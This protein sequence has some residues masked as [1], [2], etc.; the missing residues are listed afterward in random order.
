M[1]KQIIII[2]VLG[3]I[4]FLIFIPVL[5]TMIKA[6]R[7]GALINFSQALGFTLRKTNTKDFFIGLAGFQKNNI[8]LPLTFLEAHKLAG[9]NLINCLNGF[10]YAKE[11][12]L[13]I[14]FRTVSAID[15]AGKNVKDSLLDLDKEYYL[16][17]DNLQNNNIK[18]DLSVRYKYSFP[19]AFIEKDEEKVKQKV[20]DK[21]QRFLDSWNSIDTLETERMII[22]NILNTDFWLENLKI[23]I[24]KQDI[25][26]RQK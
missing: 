9:G 8:D 26:V 23:I 10:L 21:L 16:R 7:L 15:L 5:I 2:I 3:I 1:D 20:K 4:G 12:G 11:K 6:K 25:T 22:V 13:E 24:V 19:N 17:I 14:D 18:L